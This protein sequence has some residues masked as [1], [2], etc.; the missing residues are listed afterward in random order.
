MAQKV[1]RSI[2][3]F[4]KDKEKSLK[5]EI[6]LCENFLNVSVLYCEFS[7]SVLLDGQLWEKNVCWGWAG[8]LSSQLA[9]P[10]FIM[11]KKFT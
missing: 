9:V 7:V 11:R 8:K 2:E 6:E 5:M 10:T 3:N 4:N 1:L